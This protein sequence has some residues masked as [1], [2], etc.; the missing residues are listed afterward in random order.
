MFLFLGFNGLL[1]LTR[2]RA[3]RQELP[4]QTATYSWEA[5]IQAETRSHSISRW[6]LGGSIFPL[7]VTDLRS[8]T[9]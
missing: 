2:T 6:V 5:S 1:E 3:G 7:D 8:E 4:Y 9:Y